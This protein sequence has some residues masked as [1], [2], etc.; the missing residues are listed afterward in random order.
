M[1]FTWETKDLFVSDYD[2]NRGM[3]DKV[4]IVTHDIY[5]KVYLGML[6]I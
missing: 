2:K 4:I 1:K 3:F 5:E 6:K